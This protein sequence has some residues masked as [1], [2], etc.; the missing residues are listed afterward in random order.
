MYNKLVMDYSDNS[1]GLWK[2][3]L[4]KTMRID[5]V[6]SLVS[7]D[8]QMV[9]IRQ[10][11]FDDAKAVVGSDALDTGMLK[12]MKMIKEVF[13][14]FI[15]LRLYTIILPCP[16]QTGIYGKHAI[17]LMKIHHLFLTLQMLQLVV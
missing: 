4:A 7:S 17:Y 3:Y 2:G 12:F 5:E 14:L 10:V 15:L 8:C 6:P 16:I 9:D 13:A 11:S 1:S